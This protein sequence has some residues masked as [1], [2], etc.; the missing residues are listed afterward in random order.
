MMQDGPRHHDNPLEQVWEGM[1]VLDAD[2]K[3]IGKI[4]LVKM[5]DPEAVTAQGNE[6]PAVEGVTYPPLSAAAGM[7]LLGATGP[8]PVA[9]LIQNDLVPDVPEPRRSNLMRTGFIRVDSDGWFAPDRYVSANE[10]AGVEDNTVRL[11]L[12]KADFRSED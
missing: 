3:H 10:V 12:H 1:D 9:P 8:S 4:E 5:G 7:P 2:G 6:M 11:T